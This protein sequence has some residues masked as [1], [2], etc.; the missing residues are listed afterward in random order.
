MNSS[1]RYLR[2]YF[3][4]CR[5]GLARELAFRGNFMIKLFVE[6]LWL[7]IL[8]AFYETIFTKTNQV[9]TWSKPEYLFF[10]GCYF[11]LAGLIETLFL[12]NCNEFADL[13]RTGDLDFYLLKPIDEQFLVTCREIDWSS[14]ANVLM[15][16]GVM[17][18]ALYE[19]G[20]P[21]H[22]G[23]LAVF[24]LLF[25]CGVMIAY[26]FLVALTSISVWFKRNQSLYEL[27]W[28]FT[29]LMRYPREIFSGS[30]AGQMGWFFTYVM[31]VLIVV[32]VPA[33]TLVRALNPRLAAFMAVVALAAIYLSRKF[34]RA[35]LQRYRSASS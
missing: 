1:A 30:L 21:F 6:V 8:L 5:Y 22:A 17:A 15:G 9:A 31:P 20:W 19:M 25:L 16:M 2:L 12:Q 33:D 29:S 13:V 26:S 4:L 28:L 24:V 10:V 34:F 3:G 35:A 18:S 23:R 14:A 32:S 27:W 11:A 7:F